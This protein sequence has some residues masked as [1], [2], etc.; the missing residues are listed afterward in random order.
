[1]QLD[2][3]LFQNLL[4]PVF[5]GELANIDIAGIGFNE[6]FQH[7][8]SG[9]LAG[10]IRTEEG[11]ALCSRLDKDGVQNFVASTKSE[12]VRQAVKL[13]VEYVYPYTPSSTDEAF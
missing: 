2:P 7:L 8:A 5:K 12:P 6:P 10:T 1:M 13:G 4:T 9:G 3:D 11:E